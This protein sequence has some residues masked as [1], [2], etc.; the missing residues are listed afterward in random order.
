M[1]AIAIVICTFLLVSC[2][3]APEGFSELDE[4]VSYQMLRFGDDGPTVCQSHFIEISCKTSRFGQETF[5]Y[6]SDYG[7]QRISAE[8]IAQGML[9]EWICKMH[10][11][12]SMRFILPFSVLK[13]GLLDE[14]TSDDYRLPDT[15]Q[16]VL[17]IGV[18][19]LQTQEEYEARQEEEY[20]AGVLEEN[21]YLRQHLESR[22]LL[23]LCDRMEDVFMIRTKEREGEYLTSGLEIAL[24]YTGHFLDGT[25]F[26]DS[27]KDQST[28]YFQLGKPDQ[29]IRGI[30]LALRKMRNGEE[31]RLY[32]P[33]HLAFGQKGSTTGVVPALTPLMFKVRVSGV[34][35]P[36]D[37]TWT[38]L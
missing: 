4:V 19:S 28:L 16:L 15:T 38:R 10:N 33:S 13:D 35:N 22:R 34:F 9:G 31:A 21:E 25:E 11:Q 20:R 37:S 12:D 23:S 2:S 7:F 36:S 1:R 24:D 27:S 32:I 26:D 18:L 3:N 14:F 30:D 6:H 29:V 17:D 5:D 8:F